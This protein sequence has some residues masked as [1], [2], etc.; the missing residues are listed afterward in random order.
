FEWRTLFLVALPIALLIFGMMYLFM[1]NITEQR[2]TKIDFTSIFL[3]IIGFGSMLYG[4][5]QLQDGG[6]IETF[7]IISLSVGAL[8]LVLFEWRTLFLVALSIALLIFGMMYLFM[9]NITE[10][11]ETKIDF[12][13]IF[14][15]I[16]GFGSMLYGFTQLQD[17]GPIETFTIIS[18]SVGALALVLF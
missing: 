11:R 18:L 17:G 3:S 16:I 4:F 2:E 12:T 5:T 1:R 10:Q 7:T 9:R 14:L 13:S 8:A 6:P 15:S